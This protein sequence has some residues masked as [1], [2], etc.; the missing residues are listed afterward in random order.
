MKD[1]QLNQMIEIAV[2]AAIALHLRTRRSQ[3]QDVE[4]LQGEIEKLHMR[5]EKVEQQSLDGAK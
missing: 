2:D 1:E 4:M 3:R 5:I